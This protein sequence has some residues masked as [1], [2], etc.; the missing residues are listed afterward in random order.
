LILQKKMYFLWFIV[1]LLSAP[2]VMAAAPFFVS[3][4]PEFQSIRMDEVA[5]YQLTITNHLETEA[6]FEIYSPDV[7]WDVTVV[8]VSDRVMTVPAGE[9]K[10]AT[11][12]IR[13]LY[14]NP[15]RYGVVLNVRLS[16]RD[17]L[18]RSYAMV[19]VVGLN[20]P[21]EEYLPAIRSTIVMDKAVDPRDNVTV[22][23]ELENQNRRDIEEMDIK[24]RS[25]VI[26]AE[27]K[28][29]IDPLEKKFVAIRVPV[30]ALT[31]PQKDVLRV[32]IFTTAA[33]QTYQYEATPFE[34]EIVQYGGIEEE[35][36]VEKEFLK[37]KKTLNL[38]N[39]GNGDVADVYKIK[40]SFFT[41][42]FTSFDPAPQ[43]VEEEGVKYNGWTL[44]LSPNEKATITIT[45]SYRVPFGI[46]C[47]IAAAVLLYFLLRSPV[48]VHKSATVLATSEGGISEI[49]VLI[50]V[51]NRAPAA[52]KK[53]MIIDKVPHIAEVAREFEMGTLH[54][55]K[56]FR[57]EKKG[58]LIKW[59]LKELDKFEERVL[60]Y[61]IKSRL[62]VLGEFK[63]PVTVVRHAAGKRT[64]A[65]HSNVVTL[66][67]A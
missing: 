55:T 36:S 34:F 37:T 58:T 10:T 41:G 31:R 9:S 20:Q 43:K 59:E 29:G 21:T 27:Y 1:L 66:V 35:E 12:Q 11:V 54:P 64:R 61:K 19:G 45:T 63:L 39:R 26:N 40:R 4:A 51:K 46:V 56:V 17:M 24:L 32:L 22:K 50:V 53:V 47:I 52:L 25:N 62:S 67:G 18:I 33:G 48:V 8:P 14:V 44:S 38:V 65:A 3:I 2:A 16:G 57:H 7:E 30:D 13:P 6:N 42:I 60:A 49:K 15:G 5:E 23:I 28:T